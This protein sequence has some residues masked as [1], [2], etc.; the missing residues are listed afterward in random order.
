MPSLFKW[1]QDL[2]HQC[3]AEYLSEMQNCKAEDE[4]LS[5]DVIE[6]IQSQMCLKSPD[7]IDT[8]TSCMHHF[9]NWHLLARRFCGSRTDLS[10][11]RSEF[12]RVVEGIN[13]L[14]SRVRKFSFIDRG[15]INEKLHERRPGLQLSSLDV[16]S[17]DDLLETLA[18]AVSISKPVIKRGGRDDYVLNC[19]VIAMSHFL[20]ALE[21]LRVSPNARPNRNHFSRDR[22]AKII[23]T[24]LHALEPESTRRCTEN[25]ITGLIKK[26]EKKPE[27]ARQ[28][29]SDML[30]LRAPPIAEA[31]RQSLH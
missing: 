29:F 13:N 26:M 12:D 10:K 8:V 27:L 6:Q 3:A 23:Q 28:A 11:S 24:F 16:L 7:I 15:T 30:Q 22:R 17:V 5:K 20:E 2:R 31:H 1:P 14:R 18:E 9:A 4:P 25:Y 19:T 21:E